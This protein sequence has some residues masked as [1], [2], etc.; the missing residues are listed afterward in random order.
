MA[1]DISKIR[2][3]VEA[4]LHARGL[5]VPPWSYDWSPIVTQAL[6]QTDWKGR[7]LTGAILHGPIELNGIDFTRAN[8]SKAHFRDVQLADATFVEANL[9]NAIIR[10]V[11]M[12][13]GNLKGADLTG[14][15]LS[16]TDLCDADLSNANLSGVELYSV[17]LSRAILH[18]A[19]LAGATLI[20]VDLSGADLTGANLYGVTIKGRTRLDRADL[21][22]ALGLNSIVSITEA[23]PLYAKG[24]RGLL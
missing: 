12:K 23:K 10:D 18:E 5:P 7:N 8:L 21:S 6:T 11:D 3:R 22:G 4:K 14:V 20:D 24:K 19:D 16:D 13:R 9:T 15:D 17:D 1:L 2:E